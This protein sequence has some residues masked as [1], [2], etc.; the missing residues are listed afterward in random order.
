[1]DGS[2]GTGL[3]IP[4]EQ[5]AT[6]WQRT[7]VNDDRL[8]R[9]QTRKRRV[10]PTRRSFIMRESRRSILH[11]TSSQCRLRANAFPPVRLCSATGRNTH[12]GGCS[13]S[14]E[15]R[16][17]FVGPHRSVRDSRG[18]ALRTDRSETRLSAAARFDDLAAVRASGQAALERS[19]RRA[20][21]D[22]ATAPPRVVD[23]SEGRIVVP[24]THRR[25]RR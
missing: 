9:R 8:A 24:A 12:F 4:T 20:M 22:A 2:V 6:Q 11:G 19:K 3:R 18:R 13:P 5:N 7:G 17:L 16:S 10:P 21:V 15:R 25:L 23:R 1:L 14:S